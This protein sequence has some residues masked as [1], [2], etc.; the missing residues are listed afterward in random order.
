MLV[1]PRGITLAVPGE[2]RTFSAAIETSTKSR[3]AKR[4]GRPCSLYENVELWHN[5]AVPATI[6]RCS[7]WRR[8][9]S[10]RRIIVFQRFPPIETNERT[11]GTAR[12]RR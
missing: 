9:L 2:S 1:T 5:Y 4:F 11:C 3:A 12:Y 10:M 8:A 7:A 6:S